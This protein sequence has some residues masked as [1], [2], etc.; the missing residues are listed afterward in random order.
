[1]ISYILTKLTPILL[2]FKRIPISL[3]I[4]VLALGL[5]IVGQIMQRSTYEQGVTVGKLQADRVTDAK[6]DE[7]KRQT[8]K[9]NAKIENDLLNLQKKKQLRSTILD[10]KLRLA[11][12]GLPD[13]TGNNPNCSVPLSVINQINEIR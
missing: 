12:N 1:M 6:S 4:G 3:M 8:E 5:L 9:E 7:L 10:E 13:M 11:V 2:P